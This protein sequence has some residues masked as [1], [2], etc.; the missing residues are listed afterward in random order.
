MNL[1]A[2]ADID[3]DYE[4]DGDDSLNGSEE[5]SDN[6]GDV[7]VEINVESLVAQIEREHENG[8]IGVVSARKRLEEL[9]EARRS[10]LELEDFDDYDL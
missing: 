7:S 2:E 6:V 5:S 10:A 3:D 9:M 1:G 8:Q 4:D